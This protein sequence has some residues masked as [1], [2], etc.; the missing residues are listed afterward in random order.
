MK[1]SFMELV[2]EIK[3]W[4]LTMNNQDLGKM[5]KIAMIYLDEHGK[6]SIDEL[7]KFHDVRTFSNRRIIT[8]NGIPSLDQILEIHSL[9]CKLIDLMK[10]IQE[11]KTTHN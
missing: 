1:T 11:R 6:I 4:S 9:E 3:Q 10:K 2:D 7:S 8:K 5:I